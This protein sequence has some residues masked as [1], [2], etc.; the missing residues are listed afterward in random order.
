MCMLAPQVR[1][2]LELRIRDGQLAP[3]ALPKEAH[4]MLGKHAAAGLIETYR[5]HAFGAPK[6]HLR[7]VRKVLAALVPPDGAKL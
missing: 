6:L 7:K 3:V 5:K 1:Q 2:L 4:A